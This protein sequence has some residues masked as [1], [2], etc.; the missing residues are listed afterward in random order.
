MPT[1]MYLFG[2][3]FYFYSDE[4]LPIHVHVAYCK[5]NCKQQ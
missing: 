3:R 4:H 1:I 5:G 2:L